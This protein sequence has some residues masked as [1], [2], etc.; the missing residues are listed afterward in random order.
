MNERK[1]KNDYPSWIPKGLHYYNHL[2]KPN[3]KIS[4]G[5]YELYLKG[6][7]LP[8][9]KAAYDKE[10]KE[11]KEQKG[12][13]ALE[14]ATKASGTGKHKLNDTPRFCRGQQVCLFES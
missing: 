6:T 14:D 10:Q 12:K 13:K 9:M 1:A 8:A 7:Y 11:Q 2:H 3:N 4:L 5:P